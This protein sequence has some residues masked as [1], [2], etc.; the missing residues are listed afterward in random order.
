MG[1][2]KRFSILKTA[3]KKYKAD[4]ATTGT[5]FY[6]YDQFIKGLSSYTVEGQAR[7]KSQ[8]YKI[9]PFGI[10]STGQDFAIMGSGR[11]TDSNLSTHGLSLTELGLAALAETDSAFMDA[12][13]VPAKII[14][15]KL[16][17]ATPI[18]SKITGISYKKRPGES[19]TFPFGRKASTDN[20]FE[21]MGALSTLVKATTGDFGITF[22]PERLFGTTGV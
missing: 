14:V 2:I 1:R 5:A 11:I 9:E 3:I 19:Y 20:M 17:A 12:N 16:G 13:Y 18:D 7:G 8:R 21:R 10:A 22:K 6:K 15:K 4:T